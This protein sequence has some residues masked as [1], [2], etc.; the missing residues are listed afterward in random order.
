MFFKFI[1]NR[2]INAPIIFGWYN[3]SSSS[4]FSV[5]LFL[6][7]NCKFRIFLSFF[8]NTINS[9][10]HLFATIDGCEKLSMQISI[11]L[12]S[13]KKKVLFKIQSEAHNIWSN[14]K[15]F[16][17]RLRNSYPILLSM[18][19]QINE[20]LQL[21]FN[22]KKIFIIAQILRYNQCSRYLQLSVVIKTHCGFRIF[23]IFVAE[24]T[25]IFLIKVVQKMKTFSIHS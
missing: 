23:Q 1:S 14:S 22:C 6:Q 15:I 25:L 8:Q 19:S 13:S 7:Q 24:I 18:A 3:K 4:V 17:N 16:K 21:H 20:T 5:K 9:K 2:E 11:Y 12:V 10:F